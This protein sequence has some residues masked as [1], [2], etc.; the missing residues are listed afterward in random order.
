MVPPMKEIAVIGLGYVGL[1]LAIEFGKLYKTIGYDISETKIAAYKMHV[2]PAEELDSSEFNNSKYFE[3]TTDITKIKNADFIIIAMPTPVDENNV[4][5]FQ[6]LIDASTL[7]G[8]NMKRGSIVI[9]E[10]TVYPGAT[11]EVCIPIL[12]Q[13]SGMK[14][15]HDFNV[16]YSPERISPGDKERTLTKIKKIVSGDSPMTLAA[17]S[18][19]YQEIIKAGVYEA[20]GIRVAE[21]AKV[22]ENIQR[23]VNIALMNEL[24]TIFNKL[25]LDTNEVIDAAASKWNFNAY[26]PGLVGGHCIGVD[27]YY[28][29]S[30]ADSI[31]HNS[32]FLKTARSVNESM[33][34]FIVENALKDRVPENTTVSIFG[35]TFKEDCKDMRNSKVS[36]LVQQFI[37]A[38]VQ[39]IY[40]NDPIADMMDVMKEYAVTGTAFEDIPAADVVVLAVPHK[41]YLEMGEASFIAKLNDQGTFVDV[42]GKFERAAF[43]VVADK[44]WRL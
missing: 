15:L 32:T 1:P 30:K 22:I 41:E 11:E 26:R 29:I 5:D 9:Y 21:A 20:T 6:C 28:L 4:P 38:G 42:K 23:D 44:V 43:E 35:L 19:L 31:G 25:G 18:E 8:A 10:S 14:W 34:G 24:S 2:D 12:E 40:I 39:K 27:P 33:T 37:K 36:A 3:P 16:G 17:V 7:V 13:H